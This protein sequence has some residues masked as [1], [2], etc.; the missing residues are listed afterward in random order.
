MIARHRQLS[1]LR[2]KT[3]YTPAGARTEVVTSSGAVRKGDIV[4]AVGN[5]PIRTRLDYELALIGHASG[6]QVALEVERTG[7]P[8]SVKLALGGRAVPT[9]IARNEKPRAK[10][11]SSGSVRDQMYK[12]FGVRL[13]PADA[14]RVRAVDAMYSGGLRVAYVRKGSPADRALIR[15][16]DI[17]VGLLRWQ[18]TSWD[19][20]T[21]VLESAEVAESEPVKFHIMRGNEVFWGTFDITT[22][23]IR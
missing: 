2:V 23:G 16:G 5:H 10:L 20:V 17:L 15:T 9:A 21:W 8:V 3:V 22:Q 1:P 19:D 14:S 18:T 11:T 12:I 4:V 6:S 13:E 7:E